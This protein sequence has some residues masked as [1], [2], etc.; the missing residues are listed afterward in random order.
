MRQN[1]GKFYERI[2][3]RHLDFDRSSTALDNLETFL[4]EVNGS[5]YS[6]KLGQVMKNRETLVGEPK[7]E[8]SFFCSEL[9]AKCYK[10]CGIMV[11]TQ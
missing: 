6:L 8:R 1:L 10:V 5:K 2:A 11:P 4:K 7:E 9:I 3:V